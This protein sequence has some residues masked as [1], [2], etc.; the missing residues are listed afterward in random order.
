MFEILSLSAPTVAVPCFAHEFILYYII[1]ISSPTS[2][3]R[4]GAAR[5][6]ELGLTTLGPPI[7]AIL[8]LP[9]SPILQSEMM[10]IKRIISLE[11]TL[12][13]HWKSFSNS[14]SSRENYRCF[15]TFLCPWLNQG[16]WLCSFVIMKESQKVKLRSILTLHEDGLTKYWRNVR[17]CTA[18]VLHVTL[19]GV[20]SWPTWPSTRVTSSSTI[21]RYSIS[22]ATSKLVPTHRGM[23][24]AIVSSRDLIQVPEV[25]GILWEY[26][27]EPSDTHVKH[28]GP[29]DHFLRVPDQLG[30]FPFNFRVS[31]R[32][33]DLDFAR[34][35]TMNESSWGTNTYF[36]IRNWH[37][38][39]T[40]RLPVNKGQM[41]RSA[42]SIDWLSKT[43]WICW[44]VTI[45]YHL[46]I[47][48]TFVFKSSNAS[49]GSFSRKAR[50]KI[51]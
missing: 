22:S 20:S 36:G 39:P 28:T 3:H 6:G 29:Y 7:D 14:G 8:G 51:Q 27:E 46:P 35:A 37:L 50:R 30:K 21:S 5:P 26:Q 41:T 10:D 47:A 17:R 1:L 33:D 49:T 42:W 43:N 31:V 40:L 2:I 12:H 16:N 38:A 32:L 48:R 34:R 9:S 25:H 15:Q 44:I 45:K 11:K 23:G 13:F 24:L 18:V 19:T 4:W